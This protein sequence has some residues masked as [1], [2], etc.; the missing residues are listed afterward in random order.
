M[1]IFFLKNKIKNIHISEIYIIYYIYNLCQS[2][3]KNKVGDLSW[4]NFFK[5]QFCDQNYHLIRFI[6]KKTN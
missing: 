5:I 4:E 2:I 6:L 1:Q 3:Y